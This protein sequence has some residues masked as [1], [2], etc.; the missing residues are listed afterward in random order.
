MKTVAE[1]NAA[2]AEAL[3][4][5]VL[6]KA[7]DVMLK[8]AKSDYKYTV[9]VCGG[10]GCTSSHSPEIVEKIKEEIK[11]NG[12]EKDVQVILTGCFGLCALGPIMIVYPEG[13][14]YSRVDINNIPRIVKEH[15]VDGNPVRDLLYKE[16]LAEDGT[17]KSLDETD[18]YKKQVRVC[19]RNCGVIDPEDIDEYIAVDGYLVLNLPGLSVAQ[20]AVIAVQQI[21]YGNFKER[22]Q[23]VR[24]SFV[25][26]IQNTGL[27]VDICIS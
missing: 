22:C 1:L 26:A 10:T 9:L 20:E 11:N 8:E 16:T 23:L 17:I 15:L 18:F 7:N 24:N 5:V 13:C 6:R 2:R 27:Y 12:V 21:I 19:L 3:K 25:K 14:F 4:K